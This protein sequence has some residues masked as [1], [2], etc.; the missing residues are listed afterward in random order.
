GIHSRARH[1]YLD[2]QRHQRHQRI[3]GIGR[4]RRRRPDRHHAAGLTP[5]TAALPPEG[6]PGSISR[7]HLC[8]KL[9]LISRCCSPRST[10]WTASKQPPTPVSKASNTCSPTPTPKKTWPGV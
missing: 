8:R 10:F 4:E 5:D 9:P 7:S 6:P 2:G 1:E 3:R